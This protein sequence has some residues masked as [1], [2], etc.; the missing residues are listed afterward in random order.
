MSERLV[1]TIGG[2][3][4]RRPTRRDVLVRSTVAG[5]ALAV[6][7]V[8]YLTR[9]VSAMEVV[10]AAT[11]P[12]RDCPPGALCYADG[13]A[14][15]CCTI[16]HGVN[17][18]PAGTI[19]GGWW[20][21]DG[22]VY[23][24]GPRYYIDCVG[25][26]SRCSSG[27]STGFCPDCDTV[28][29]CD[30]ANG[31]CNNR[32]VGCRTFRYGQCNVDVGCVGRLACRVV[33]C[34]PAWQLDPSC[35]TSSATDNRTANHTAPCLEHPLAPVVGMAA[36][37]DGRGYWLA[38]TDGRVDAY[39]SATS[40]GGADDRPLND[41]V[42]GVSAARDGSGYW[43]AASDGGVF[44][45][46]VGW[47]GSEGGTRLNRPIVGIA[48][49][50]SGRGYWLV[51][52]DGGVFAFG[53]AG[54][55]GSTGAIRL[56]RPI[57][58]MASTPTGLGYWLVASDGGV[59][60]FGDAGFFGSTGA[61]SLH[62]PIV[63]MASTPA[64]LGYWLVA[65]DGGVFAFGDAG[66]FG[67]TGDLVLNAPIVGMAASATGRGYWMVASDGGIFS[68]GDAAYEGSRVGAPAA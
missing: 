19:A 57:V 53:D 17:A 21:A 24:N 31:D 32:R 64:G 6:A 50:P 61:M 4:A 25:T 52:S 63:G 27:C 13:Y 34:T 42:V 10:A 51:A 49:T 60:A 65:S 14:E 5:S 11:S 36:A 26:C 40:K 35:T 29:P 38:A 22:S 20:K 33:S 3:L 47:Y 41:P 15:F 54:F 46:G 28:P 7:P 16:N 39:G 8:R 1:R 58:G 18:C 44:A 56:N 23:C 30:C 37:P 2:W 12:T 68:F 55:F 67:S 62:R 66:F 45:F 59:F 9:P 48:G 43:L